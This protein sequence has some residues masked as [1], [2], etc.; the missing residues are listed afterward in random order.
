MGQV[1]A[2]GGHGPAGVALG[3]ARISDV[4]GPEGKLLTENGRW[5]KLRPVTEAARKV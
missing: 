1:E 5:A 4:L 3:V 2:R